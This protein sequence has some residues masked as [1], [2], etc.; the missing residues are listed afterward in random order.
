MEFTAIRTLITE[1]IQHLSS[2]GK[3]SF[4]LIAYKKDLEQFVGFL[5]SVEKSD[6]RDIKKEDIKSHLYNEKHFYTIV[7]VNGVFSKNLSS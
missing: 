3:S 5:S 1:F 4:T 2:Q 6:V 7:F